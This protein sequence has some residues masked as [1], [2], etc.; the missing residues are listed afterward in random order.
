LFIFRELKRRNV[1]RVGIAYIIAAWLVAQVLQLVFESFGAPDWVMKSVLVLLV[2]GLPFAVAKARCRDNT[3]T[4]VDRYN[5]R[6]ATI[7]RPNRLG[8]ESG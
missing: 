4:F 7:E 3:R 2:V 8:F 6:V 5:T 1:F